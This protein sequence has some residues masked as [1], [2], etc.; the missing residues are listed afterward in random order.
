MRPKRKGIAE[1]DSLGHRKDPFVVEPP[2]VSQAHGTPNPEARVTLRDALNVNLDV[3]GPLCLGR[4]DLEL[5]EGFQQFHY[6][7][8][9]EL[10]TFVSALI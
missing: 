4:Y 3:D 6:S 7:R 1:G 10:L 8:H 9:R 5:V 2:P